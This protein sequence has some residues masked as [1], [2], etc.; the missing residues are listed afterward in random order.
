MTRSELT[1]VFGQ[2]A[3][4]VTFK[5]TKSPNTVSDIKALVQSNS[6]AAESIINSFG[7]HGKQITILEASLTVVPEKFDKVVIDGTNYVIEAVSPIYDH[8]VGDTMGFRCHTKG[9]I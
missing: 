1:L 6:R 4:P 8:V 2:L 7:V 3:I 9:K 5:Q